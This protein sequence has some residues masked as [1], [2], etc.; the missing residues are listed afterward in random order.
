MVGMVERVYLYHPPYV[1]R[2]FFV[3]PDPNRLQDHISQP[4][5][6]TVFLSEKFRLLRDLN[7]FFLLLEDSKD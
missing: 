7:D 2:N 1:N 3:H 6:S 5:K 4:K